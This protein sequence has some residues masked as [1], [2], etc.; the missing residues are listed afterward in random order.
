MLEKQWGDMGQ[1]AQNY[2][3]SK[4]RDLVF[5]M[6]AIVNGMLWYTGNLLKELILGAPTTK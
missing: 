4:S 3:T 2:R 6:R 1:R 5:S